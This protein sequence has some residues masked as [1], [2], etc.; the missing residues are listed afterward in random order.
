VDDPS[1][2][3][4]DIVGKGPENTRINLPSTAHPYTIGVHM[5]SWSASPAVVATTVKIYCAGVLKQTLTRSFSTL[6]Q[7]WI[8]GQVS[9]PG[10]GGCNF[11]P[12]GS[13]LQ[14]P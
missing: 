12:N 9:F 1:L 7:M 4:D 2:D 3:R 10:P 14:V 5:Y 11:T 6:S 8:V 13:V